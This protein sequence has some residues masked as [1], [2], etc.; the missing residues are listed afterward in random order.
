ME[1]DSSKNNVLNTNVLVLNKLYIA[2]KVISVRR[3]F[4]F[5][6]KDYAEVI[7]KSNERFEGYRFHHWI[8]QSQNNGYPD[9]EYVHTPS[10]R[11]LVPR[12]IR[13]LAYDKMPRREWKFNRKNIMLR[14]NYQCQYCGKKCPVNRL[15]LDH[16]IPKSRGGTGNWTNVVTCCTKCNTKK[17]GRLPHEAGIKLIAKPHEPKFDQALFKLIKDKKYNI[18]KDFVTPR[19]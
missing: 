5:L 8:E 11:I 12:V 7:H 9:D 1:P 3:A 14:D 17:G 18:W 2:L 10:L 19:T 15:T 4:I 13:L 6:A 16:I